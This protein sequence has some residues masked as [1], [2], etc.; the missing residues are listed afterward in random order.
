MPNGEAEGQDGQPTGARQQGGASAVRAD[1]E[2]AEEELMVDALPEV[3]RSGAQHGAERHVLGGGVSD[4]E[5]QRR[6][7]VGQDADEVD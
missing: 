2:N 4:G 1:G 3:V 5:G 7:L 6:L